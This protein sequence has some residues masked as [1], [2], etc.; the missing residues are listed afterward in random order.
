MIERAALDK[1]IA[2]QNLSNSDRTDPLTAVKLGK[3]LGVD[4]IILGTI[5]RYDYTDKTS[6]GPSRFPFGGG[7]MK[8]KHDIKAKVLISTRLVSTDTAEVLSVSEGT[9]EIERKV[10]R[11]LGEMNTNVLMGQTNDPIMNECI[12]KAISQLALLLEQ[13]FPKVPQHIPVVEG[14]VADADDPAKL[15]LNVGAR[16]GLKI[17]D[18]LQVLRAG[19]EIRDP[20]SGKLLLR[21]DK[22]LG[23]AVVT[24]VDD[25]F[26]IAHYNGTEPVKVRDLVRSVK[27]Q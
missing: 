4:A 17:G 10:K 18:H 25:T 27:K 24:T 11:N 5:A 6:G 16:D 19:K 3:L 2:E 15:V 13:E 14:L 9:G 23:E 7:S 21:D 1:L 12:E 22:L 8:V 20:S 26:A